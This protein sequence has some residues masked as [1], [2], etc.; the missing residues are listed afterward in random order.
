VGLSCGRFDCLWNSPVDAPQTDS[1]LSKSQSDALIGSGNSPCLGVRK[2][3][4]L[5]RPTPDN[6]L[7]RPTPDNAET[8]SLES[9]ALPRGFA[10]AHFA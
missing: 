3:P 6:A 8:I 2:I 4:T 5:T 9:L 7:T 10:D 1:D